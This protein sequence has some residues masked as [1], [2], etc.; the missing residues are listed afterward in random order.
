MAFT[1]P[2]PVLGLS[3]A[4]LAACT[5]HGRAPVPA[6]HEEY[7]PLL[8]YSPKRNWMNDPNGL[9]YHGGEY[10]LFYPYNPNGSTWGDMS[11]A[12][13]GTPQRASRPARRRSGAAPAGRPGFGDGVRRP[14]RSGA[15]RPDISRPGLKR[16]QCLQR[17]RASAGRELEHL[18]HEID[19]AVGLGP[20]TIFLDQYGGGRRTGL[21]LGS[22]IDGSQSSCIFREL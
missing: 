11:W 13:R 22:C 12:V 6:F 8:S 1:S 21:S 3:A 7:R 20:L 19:L 4:L 5:T 2:V 16:N 18:E 10:H 15:G 14:G 9:V 17:G